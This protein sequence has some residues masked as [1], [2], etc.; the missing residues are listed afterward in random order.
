MLAW[1]L[2]NALSRMLKR[3]FVGGFGFC[4]PA[5]DPV[6]VPEIVERVRHFWMLSTVQLLAYLQRAI[7]S[8]FR[9]GKAAGHL[10]DK[11]EIAQCVRDF[12][13]IV[14]ELL[15]PNS[16]GPASMP[17]RPPIARQHPVVAAEVV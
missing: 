1:S 5:L 17:V 3:A 9:F 12:R 8:F 14:A 2:P 11:P 7:E 10:I 4:I 16:T 13:V 6:S 15:L